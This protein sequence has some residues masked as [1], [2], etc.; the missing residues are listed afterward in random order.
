VVTDQAQATTSATVAPVT[1]GAP[2]ATVTTVATVMPEAGALLAPELQAMLDAHNRLRAQHCAA[3]LVWSDAIARAA[4][5]WADRLA[6]RGCALQHSESQYGE[7]IAAGSASTQTPDQVAALW[8]REK[9][10]Y[11]FARGGFSMRSG[12]FTQVV[13]RGSQR[14]GCAPAAC[15][16]IRLWVCNYDPPGNMQGD[17]ARNV[18]P[19]TCKP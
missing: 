11:D 17:F 6:S 7:N 15:G 4:K 2:S 5:A 8:Y 13:W 9:D 3:P 12:H 16:D 18:L 10:H 14:L 19:T 1:T